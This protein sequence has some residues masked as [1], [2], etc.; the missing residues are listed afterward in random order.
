MMN[1][2]IMAGWTSPVMEELLGPNSPIPMS[3]DESSWIVTAMNLGIIAGS[4]PFGA[5]ADRWGRKA[6][7]QVIGP[8]AL[9]TWAA[10]L[11]VNSFRGLLMVRV[12]QGI[13]AGGAC[14]VMPV[15]VGEVAGP[16]IRGA[17]GTLFQIMLFAGIMYVY[18]AGVWLDYGWLTYAAAIG[19]VLSCALFAFVPESPQF[20]VMRDRPAAARRALTWLRGGGAVDEELNEAMRS[21]HQETR[22]TS[23]A[24]LF[25]DRVTVRS[26]CVVQALS[27]FRITA[28]VT[29]LISYASVTFAEMHVDV[30]SKILSLVLAGSA[31][32]FALPATAM[33]DRL[34]RRPLMIVSCALCFVFDALI[35]TYFYLDRR[36]DYDVTSYGWLCVLAVSGLSAS[37]TL[38]LG[39]LLPTINCE[40]FSSN[41][42]SI[43]NALN[44]VTMFTVSFLAS[45]AY[46]VLAIDGG[47]Y[48]NYLI[49]ALFSLASVVF[50]WLWLPETKGMTLA[51]IQV[52]L[53]DTGE[54]V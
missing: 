43:A 9:V 33:A 31:A 6:S 7:L 12:V 47:M 46:P 4:I 39:S 54:L 37:H 51:A 3:V 44:T 32:A 45:K 30:D 36:T 38:G 2:G 53:R 26:L 49:S 40:L 5:V 27:V 10:L 34:G 24:E 48:R 52:R 16:E 42:R 14:T 25:A 17:L 13:L 18:T 8:A 11:Y 22:T 20:Y 41:T 23:F 28:G 1:V 29:A 19:P 50:C 15:Y 21:V 35:F